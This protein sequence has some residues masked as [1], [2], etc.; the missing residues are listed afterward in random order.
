MSGPGQHILLVFGIAMRKLARLVALTALVTLASSPA[1]ASPQS[2]ADGSIVGTVTANG[3]P[4]HGARVVLTRE[5][6]NAPLRETVT[7]GDDAAVFAFRGL[8]AGRYVVAVLECEPTAPPASDPSQRRVK[9]AAHQAVDG[10]ALRLSCGVAVAGQVVLAETGAPLRTF[11]VCYAADGERNNVAY[12][13]TGEDG[14][15]RAEGLV[16][17]R[18]YAYANVQDSSGLV[19]AKVEFTVGPNGAEGLEVRVFR[20]ATIAG[21][22]TVEG[23]GNGTLDELSVRT[24]PDVSRVDDGLISVPHS[25]PVGPDGRFTLTGLRPASTVALVL[26]RNHQPDFAV[27][28]ID[29]KTVDEAQN[30]YVP[31][32]GEPA[33]VRLSIRFGAGAVRGQIRALHGTVPTGARITIGVRRAASLMVEPESYGATADAAGRFKIEQLVPGEYVMSCAL[34]PPGSDRGSFV[35]CR[36]I[37]VPEEGDAA[38]TVVVDLAKPPTTPDC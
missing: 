6:D 33:E 37:V 7:G 16:P 3:K 1:R 17:G 36:R 4:C 12:A 32:T 5:G 2:G 21:I 23:D 14:T 24:R 22:V 19:S 25:T 13:E 28:G 34:F 26:T 30:V 38:V 31:G 10:V 20:G 8:P 15:F 9:L 35:D 27:V 29:G 11:V 18:Y